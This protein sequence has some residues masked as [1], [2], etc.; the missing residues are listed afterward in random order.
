[1]AARKTAEFSPV[2]AGTLSSFVC[3]RQTQKINSKKR[4]CFSSLQSSSVFSVFL[5]FIFTMFKPF[6]YKRDLLYVERKNIR[7]FLPRSQVSLFSW[8]A[9][10]VVSNM[11]RA[12]CFPLFATKRNSAFQDHTF[13]KAGSIRCSMRY[14]STV[15]I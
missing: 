12:P 9:V 4:G 11:H 3:A 2:F 13:S 1:M 14:N 10:P 5:S 15:V 6:Q 8:S 7:Q